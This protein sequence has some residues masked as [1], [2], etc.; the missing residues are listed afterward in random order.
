MLDKKQIQAV[1]Y[2]SWKWVIKQWRQLAPST[3][4]LAQELLT[5]VQYS[6]SSRNFAKETRALKMR[7]VVSDHQKLTTTESHHQSWSCY[8]YTRSCW[9]TSIILWLFSIW[10]KLDRWTQ[11]SKWVPPELTKNE[12]KIVIWKCHFLLFYATL[13]FYDVSICCYLVARS[14]NLDRTGKMKF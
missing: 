3:M 11:L 5:N 7:S 12:K 4:H 6:G 1:S 8:N 2:S 14:M 13:T 10:S 9:R